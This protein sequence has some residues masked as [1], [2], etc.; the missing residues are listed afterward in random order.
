M[1]RASRVCAEPGCPVIVTAGH[2]AQHARPNSHRRGY[3]RTHRNLRARWVPLVAAGSVLCWRC[4]EAIGATEAWD[5]GHDDVDRSVTRGP[6]HAGRCNRS[7][8]GR[9]AHQR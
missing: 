3:D 2:C 1:P 9:A 5:L 4:G 8:A 7:T 6:E